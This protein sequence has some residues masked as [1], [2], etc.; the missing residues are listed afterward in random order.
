[1]ICWITTPPNHGARS[2]KNLL[3]SSV[4]DGVGWRLWEFGDLPVV[5]PASGARGDRPKD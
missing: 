3:Y 2:C 1:M 4:K 5:I